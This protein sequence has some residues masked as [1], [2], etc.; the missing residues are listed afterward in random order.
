MRRRISTG[1]RRNLDALR[2]DVVLEL[3]IM[4]SSTFLFDFVGF[5]VC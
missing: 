1:S 4:A 3:I 2:E 5:P